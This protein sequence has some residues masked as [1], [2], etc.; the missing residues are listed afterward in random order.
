MWRYKKIIDPIDATYSGKFSFIY[1]NMII[2]REWKTHVINC[3]SFNEQSIISAF[4]AVDILFFFLQTLIETW[5]F[6]Y[7]SEMRDGNKFH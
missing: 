7:V 1:F 3:E 4:T 6:E 2:Q 5:S